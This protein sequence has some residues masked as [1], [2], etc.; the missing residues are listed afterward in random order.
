MWE[1]KIDRD[2]SAPKRTHGFAGFANESLEM[3]VRT[4]PRSQVK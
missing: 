3:Q 4:Q 2:G 1:A